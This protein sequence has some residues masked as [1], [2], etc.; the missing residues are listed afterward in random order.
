[1][2]YSFRVFVPV[3][4]FIVL[5]R[6]PP[7]PSPT[8]VSHQKN[9][10][11]SNISLATLT[12][13]ASA[14]TSFDIF[15]NKSHTMFSISTTPARQSVTETI[16]V[17]SGRL[18]SA[19]LLE[20]RR[21][22]ILSL[23]S[24][25]KDFPA[26]VAS[27]A[28][29]SL[30]SSLTMDRDDIDTVKVTLETLLMLFNPN[31]SSPEASDE[32]ALWLADE[33]TQRQENTRILVDLME[34]AD[35]Y[36]RLYTI[37]L[38]S[39]ILAARTQRM[40][41]CV[42]TAPLGLSRLV[43]VL[44][45]DREAIRNE[46]LNLLI[47]L[48]PASVEIQKVVAFQ[49]AYERIFAI[50]ETEGSLIEGGRIVEDCLI[51]LANLLRQN[52]SNQSLFRESGCVNRLSSV[53]RIAVTSETL[54]VDGAP[55][56]QVQRNRNIYAFLALLRLFL[57]SDPPGVLQ[58]QISFSKHSLVDDVLH[59]AFNRVTIAHVSIRA[60]ALFTCG[61]MIRNAQHLQESFAQLTI[62]SFLRNSEFGERDAYVIDGL[63]D[64]IL[65]VHDQSFFY[66]R[67]AACECLKAYLLNHQQVKLHFLDRAVKGFE[68][69]SDESANILTALMRPHRADIGDPYR[70]WF[71][72]VI[73]FHLLHENPPAKAKLLGLG[74]GDRDVGEELVT[75]IQTI[76]AHLLSG[77]GRGNDCRS[78]VGYMM[79]LSSWMFEDL[80]AVNNFLAEG[81]T[82]QGLIQ[83]ASRA[84]SQEAELVEGM[85]TMLLGVIYEFSTKDSPIPRRK[86]HSILLSELGRDKYLERLKCF[87]NHPLIRDFEVT[88]QTYDASLSKA[89]PPVFF[90]AEFVDFFKDNYR[91]ITR[92][93]DRSPD[94]EASVILNDE[95]KGVSRDL[96][97]SLRRQI[98]ERDRALETAKERAASLEVMLNGE[99]AE[100]LHFREHI[101]S[102]L[103]RSKD[104][105]KALEK[106][107][108]AKLSEIE[109]QRIASDEAF[110]RR[111]ASITR[112]IAANNAEHEMILAQARRAAE[113][114]MQRVRCR[115]EME[116]TELRAMIAQAETNLLQ[117]K[118]ENDSKVDAM[119][120][121]NSRLT[122]KHA[123]S[124]GAAERRAED[125]EKQLISAESK[126]DDLQRCVQALEAEKMRALKASKATQA[127]LDDLL[128]VLGDMEDK[129]A[130]Y[131]VGQ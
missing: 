56:V 78:S 49:N 50:I 45:D 88:A 124:L 61:D 26:S 71:A 80:E 83:A 55:W 44:E 125:L 40:E 94:F 60:E 1:M 10:E 32:I 119:Q 13:R 69:G 113:D 9:G 29:R 75:S 2:P 77:I 19:T 111:I 6:P 130:K 95:Q 53:L 51:L 131:E 23:R 86:L 21:A 39:A 74:E 59:L 92:A 87:R 48:T 103:S 24:F 97:D 91:R 65:N 30:I 129:I 72:S 108:A 112:G 120:E 5:G 15:Y 63:L 73:A 116:I 115:A 41:E 12:S 52:Q 93:I 127:E 128:V 82:V 123:F 104:A 100:N 101:T 31:D 36:S 96:V 28:L 20:D 64:L 17:L 47:S 121:E 107:H 62:P 3:V 14:I 126:V 89:L 57:S 90:D 117:V 22:A 84:C 25:A 81:S 110:E 70:L 18:S 4:V 122:A 8:P 106:S 66:L 105:Y 34:S 68:Q 114:E 11:R 27:A 33:F 98:E 58:N 43:G 54:E 46:A 118:Q 85:S 35:F 67:Y 102:K 76:S 109:T 38:L 7:P 79:L 42:L 99:R 37:Q 16:N